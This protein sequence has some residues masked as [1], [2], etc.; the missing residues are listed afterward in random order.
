METG[1]LDIDGNPVRVGD[2]VAHAANSALRGRIVSEEGRCYILCGD[3]PDCMRYHI[4]DA[5]E[6]R[7]VGGVNRPPDLEA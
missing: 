1:H 2:T 6:W 4:D 7:V 3:E 5:H